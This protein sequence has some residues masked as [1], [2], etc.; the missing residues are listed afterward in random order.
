MSSYPDDLVP[1]GKLLKPKGLNG[2]LR[3]LVFNEL[4]TSMDIGTELWIKTKDGYIKRTIEKIQIADKKSVV[5]FMNCDNRSEAEHIHGK[6]FF[7]P[8]T[9]FKKLGSNE[10]YLVDLVG[11]QVFD[12]NKKNLGIIIDILAMPSQHLIVVKS[13]DG[14][15]LIPH[16]SVHVE[17]F[18][19]KMKQLFVKGIEGLID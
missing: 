2:E 9:K 4:D 14:E 3:V 19:K 17:L 12:E 15:I 13:D 16:V 5:K 11:S 6:D 8:R 18:D 7:L 10:Y 1:L